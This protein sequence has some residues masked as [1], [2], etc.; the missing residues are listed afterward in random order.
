MEILDCTLRDG[1][2]ATNFDFSERDVS[3]LCKELSAASVRRIEVGHGQGL[4]APREETVTL[5][6]GLAV[7]AAKTA[8]GPNSLV[9]CFALPQYASEAT[10]AEAVDAG[11]DFVR[12]GVP[13]EAP[14]EAERLLKML[15]NHDIEVFLNL[16]KSQR[17]TKP[18]LAQAA[19]LAHDVGAKAVY[20][21]DSAGGMTRD[22]VR[23]HLHAVVGHGVRA[24]FH[25]HDNLGLANANAVTAV[26]A[27]ASYVDG[28]LGGLGR[29]AGNARTE[30]LSYLLGERRSAPL[31]HLLDGLSY[32]EPRLDTWSRRT[33]FDVALGMAK[34]HSEDTETVV[35]YARDHGCD[36]PVGLLT[37]MSVR[38]GNRGE[39]GARALAGA[40]R[41][42]CLGKCTT[43]AKA[44]R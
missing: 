14:R 16:L 25:G 40:L 2:Y 37:A 26:E 32:L 23:R 20:V 13:A 21:V 38:E 36:D 12:V 15:A 4:G 9:G 33:A 8:A 22:E 18:F 6:D 43:A 17:L 30:V 24:G 3:Y 19:E 28:T 35:A 39:T 11:V 7:T 29:S 34:V 42:Y 5:A 1:G 27:G 10:I 41:L 44:R 31:K